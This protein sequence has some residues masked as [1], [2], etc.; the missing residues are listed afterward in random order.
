M[1]YI[2]EPIRDFDVIGENPEDIIWKR[3]DFLKDYCHFNGDVRAYAKLP[4][5]NKVLEAE[6]K[7]FEGPDDHL[8]IYPVGFNILEA[9]LMAYSDGRR[10]KPS[11]LE[12]SCLKGE[13]TVRFGN[14]RNP[15]DPGLSRRGILRFVF[16][17]S[18]R[19]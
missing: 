15:V 12:M 19:K 5:E 11:Y 8:L 14:I 2:L 13:T 10:V 9:G 4:F 17:H 7:S 16:M 6:L 1:G 3:L 18:P